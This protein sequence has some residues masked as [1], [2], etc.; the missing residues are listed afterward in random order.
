MPLDFSAAQPH[1]PQSFPKIQRPTP[2]PTQR[3]KIRV[4]MGQQAKLFSNDEQKKFLN[5]YY[6]ISNRAD[7]MG[8]HL[9]GDP[10]Q[11]IDGHDVVSDGIVMGSIQ[12]PGTGYPIVLMADRQPTGGY[13][14]IA[15][16]VTADLP[17]FSQLRPG[18]E[19][20]FCSVSVD[21]ARNALRAMHKTL[22]TCETL[23]EPVL[24]ENWRSSEFLLSQN[25]IGGAIACGD[26][27]P[28]VKH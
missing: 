15:T 5:Q 1:T 12:V 6:K 25:L 27:L 23:F 3:A 7:R 22:S 16:I 24:Q 17:A 19:F 26:H 9:K 13:P 4:I 11:H 14:K 2:H 10:L 20:Q 18:Q 28:W 8:V 21:E